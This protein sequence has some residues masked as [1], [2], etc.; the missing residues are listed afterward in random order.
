LL[1][2]IEK[3]HKPVFIVGCGRS[4]TTMLFDLLS[5]HP[6]FIRTNGYPDGEDHDGWIKHGSCVMA[7]IGNPYN[8]K[9][10]NG[11]NG[12]QY[13]LH[14]TK[15]D[16]TEGI[17]HDMHDYYLNEVLCGNINKRVLNK[18]PHLSNKL[19]YVLDIFPDAKII[20]IIRDCEPMVAS[21]KAVMDHVSSL[22]VYFPKDE[23]FPCLWLMQNPEDSVAKSLIDKH[24]QFY[25]GG[26]EK[27]FIDYWNKVNQG[28]LKQM[29][30]RENQL[31]SIRYEDLIKHPLRVTNKLISFCELPD[32]SFNFD[33]FQQDTAKKHSHRMSAELSQSVLT[34]S[35]SVRKHFGYVASSSKLAWSLYQP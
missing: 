35:N 6:E 32:F 4:G 31:L 29:I 15:E 5:K 10:G 27:L 1:N 9:F 3:I 20:H 30:G 18:Q 12:F 7:G 2:D 33:H 28:I 14:M 25:P 19:D 34:L 11:I 22:L 16:V 23:E 21:W 24:P 13:C 8:P 17:I 26:G